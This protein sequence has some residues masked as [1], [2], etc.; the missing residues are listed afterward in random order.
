MSYTAE[1]SRSN[2][3]C[4]IFLIDQSGSMEDPFGAGESAK[5]KSEGV[6]DAINRLLQ[7]LVIKCAKEEGIRDY[8]HVAVVGYGDN[9]VSSAFGG[10][11]ATRDLVPISEIGNTPARIEERTKKEDDGA[12]GLFERKVKFPIWFEPVAGG[13]T[14]MCK[15]LNY[16]KTLL[17]NWISNH[18]GCFPPIVI[19]ISDG[20]ATDGDPGPLAEEIKN[21]SSDDGNVLLFNLHCSSHRSAPIEF[22]GEENFSLT[23]RFAQLLYKMSSFLPEHMINAA[24]Q[25]GYPVSASSRGFVFNAGIESVVKFLDIGTR[26]SNLR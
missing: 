16:A 9:K 23:D 12:G 6:S 7:N 22:P 4:F 21:L 1:I 2:P 13:G 26:P 18:S 17:Q 10:N 24:K 3:S 20:E 8:Y 14:P 25:E 19:N 15:A 5:K 11:L